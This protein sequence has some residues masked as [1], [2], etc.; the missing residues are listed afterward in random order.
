LNHGLRAEADED[1]TFCRSLSE[2]LSLP[3]ASGRRRRRGAERASARSRT[4]AERPLPVPRSPGGSASARR[5]SPWPYPRRSGG[6]VSPAPSPRFGLR[7]LGAIH[8]VKD[9]GIVRPSSKY[10]GGR[11]SLPQERGATFAKTIERRPAVH[12]EPDPTPGA[13]AA[14]VGIQPRLVETLARSAA[15]QGRGGVDGGGTRTLSTRWPRSGTS[16]STRS[17]L[18]APLASGA[19]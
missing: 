19:A 1:E 4:R 11:S 2:K 10:G 6:D 7:G 3:F 13:P 8:P 17:A 5:E 16:R 12:P 18:S 14:F 9:G 15:P